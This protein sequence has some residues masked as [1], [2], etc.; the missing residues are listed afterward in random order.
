[1]RCARVV[2]CVVC[3]GCVTGMMIRWRLLV[4]CAGLCIEG[5]G[6]RCSGGRRGGEGVCGWPL[7]ASDSLA[8]FAAKASACARLD[9]SAPFD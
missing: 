8:K 3:V 2:V 7:V 5:F 9:A 6:R 4:R 1:M